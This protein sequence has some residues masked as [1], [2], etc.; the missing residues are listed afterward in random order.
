MR[1]FTLY[2]SEWKTP[3]DFYESMLAVLEAPRW[4]GANMNALIDSMFYGGINNIDPPYKI[5]I[6]GAANLPADVKTELGWLAEAVEEHGGLEKG[7]A[8]QVDP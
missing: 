5:W 3:L 1:T 7:I 8:L 6:K 4:H 2:A